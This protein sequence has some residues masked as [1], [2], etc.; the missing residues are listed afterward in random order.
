MGR[1][2][3]DVEIRRRR[4]VNLDV[5]LE[6]APIDTVP[7]RRGV[8]TRMTL[9]PEVELRGEIEPP[10]VGDEAEPAE[11]RLELLEVASDHGVEQMQIEPYKLAGPSFDVTEID[12]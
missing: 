9:A 5:A 2:G 8:E 12:D 10:G 3:H 4:S 11:G 6:D 1:H 7:P